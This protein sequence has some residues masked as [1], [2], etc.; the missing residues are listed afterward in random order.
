VAKVAFCKTGN[1]PSFTIHDSHIN[2]PLE[3][4]KRG[5]FHPVR[6]AFRRAGIH[7][8]PSTR[9]RKLVPKEAQPSI[10]HHS[11]FTI[12]PMQ[13]RFTKTQ[14]KSTDKNAD[15]FPCFYPWL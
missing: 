4:D 13:R 8:S 14:K 7:L 15:A 9:R 6:T 2:E 12:H 3:N 11:P 1:L 10:L 5:L